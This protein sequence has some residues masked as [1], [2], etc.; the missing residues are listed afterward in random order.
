M[1]DFPQSHPSLNVG[2]MM[3]FSDIVGNM[4]RTTAVLSWK[5]S[6]Y[7]TYIH[8]AHDIAAGMMV[9]HKYPITGDDDYCHL[10][11]LS[12][13]FCESMM[14]AHHMVPDVH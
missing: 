4:E 7:L 8:R 6:R 1:V 11:W 9:Y 13:Q 5:D 10:N 14:A 3:D 2:I 12:K